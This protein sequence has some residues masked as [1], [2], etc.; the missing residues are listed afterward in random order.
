MEAGEPPTSATNFDAADALREKYR[1]SATSGS[2]PTATRS[3]R[4]WQDSTPTI[5]TTLR[6]PAI[7]AGPAD[8][9][10]V[11]VIGGGFGG[12]LAAARLREAGV[13]D[14]R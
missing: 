9:V 14:I 7:S 4:R 10:E 1:T 13:D 11:V 3:T 5:W 2:A 8:E 6:R 12:L